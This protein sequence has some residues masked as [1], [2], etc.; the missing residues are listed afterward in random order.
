MGLLSEGSPLSW[1]E[2]KALAQH[3]RE[4]GI[5]QFINM[6]A[7]LR[8]RQGDMLKWGDEVEYIIVRFDDEQK[9]AQ[10]SLRAREMLA[11]LNEKEAADP[12]GVKSLWRPEYGAYMI[13]G[14]PGKPYGGLLAHFNV[15]EANMR[16]RRLE[17]A[18]ML[19]PGEHVMSIT[20]F[21]RLGCPNFTFPPAKPTPE[22]ETCAARSLYFP[23]EAIFPGHPRF[24]TLTRNI[25]QRRGEKVSIDLPIFK[26]KNTVIPVEGSLP[27]KPDHV[28]MD[29]M[30][31]GMGCCCLQLTFQACNITEARTLYDQ[32]TPMCPIMLALTAASPAYR[33]YLTDVDCRWNVISASVDCR[34]REEKGEI[35]LKNDR[36]RINKSRYDSIDSY[37]S[38]A[39]EKYNDVPLVMDEALYKRLREG[40]IDHL[41]AQH[42]AH[43]F[44]R[45]SVS[46]FSE[47]VHQN[48]K[49]DTDHFENIQSTNWQTM[50]FK[51]P[52]PNSP[53]GWR[54]EFRPCE[55]Q[56]TDFENAAIVC[57]VVLLTRVILS[58]QLDFLIPISKVDENMQTSQKRGAVLTEKF[59]FKKNINGAKEN[60]HSNESNGLDAEYE[61]MTID[62]IINGKG[63][64]PGLVPLINSYLGSMDVD[65]DTHCTIQQYLKLIQKRASGELLTTASWIRKE[66]TEHEEY[67]HDSVVSER[68]CYDLLKKGKDIQ[69]GIRPCPELLGANVASK[70]ADNIPPAIEKHLTKHCN[71]NCL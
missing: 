71:S 6:Y 34:T 40:D 8:D 66:I 38:P 4:H 61:L 29:A 14:T 59:W 2:T 7:R 44:I 11:V 25:R 47:K 50:R 53:I 48:D 27:E 57:F 62:Q 68:I 45:D 36:F 16:Y 32:L 69:D 46:L 17:V 39:G 64:F 5:E 20:N 13:E 65:A 70:T 51:P 15:V 35:P 22:D 21:P 1:E 43:L 18:E 9:A 23:D 24:K 33:G 67:K 26:D 12:Q 3:V 54:V 28:H 19:S 56:L 58:Y 31:F 55:A 30:G 37:L 52:P 63:C 60:N 41:L 49:E 10:V 42:I